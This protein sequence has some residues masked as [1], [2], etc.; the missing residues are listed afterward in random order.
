MAQRMLVS[1]SELTD[2][3]VRLLKDDDIEWYKERTA[4][5]QGLKI[6]VHPGD[7]PQPPKVVGDMDVFNFK[8]SGYGLRIG[9]RDICF[10]NISDAQKLS[11]I[12]TKL[13]SE[14]KIYEQDDTSVSGIVKLSVL[15]NIASN[16]ALSPTKALSPL[17]FERSK[18]ALSMYEKL[19]SEWNSLDRAYDKY[20]RE[21]K[22]ITS[23]ISERINSVW[24][25]FNNMQKFARA[26]RKY[27]ELDD[28]FPT[29]KKF[30]ET[31]Y[32]EAITDEELTVDEIIEFTN[33]EDA[34]PTTNTEPVVSEEADYV[35]GQ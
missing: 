24:D 19:L 10:T 1:F 21:R 22:D 2:E 12:I 15:T 29:A 35:S 18:A 17:E 28:N 16:L 31:A 33:K 20:V 34:T 32:G 8:G 23:Y 6:A 13:A 3:Q 11:E 4:L 25:K 27:R 7:K 30:F 5:E 26:W 14:G 9:Y